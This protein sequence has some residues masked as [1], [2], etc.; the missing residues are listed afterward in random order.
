LCIIEAMKMENEITAHKAGTISELPIT[1]GSS[2][3]AGAP[4]ATIKSPE[5]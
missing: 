4:I 5:G 3:A 1:E 2:I